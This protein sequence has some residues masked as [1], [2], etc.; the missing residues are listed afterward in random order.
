MTSGLPRWLNFIYRNGAPNAKYKNH[1]NRSR[2]AISIKKLNIIDQ[3]ALTNSL[4]SLIKI[5]EKSDHQGSTQKPAVSTEPHKPHTMAP[6]R[7]P[8]PGE[9]IK[10]YRPPGTRQPKQGFTQSP[11][12]LA[13]TTPAYPQQQYQQ[14]YQPGIWGHPAWSSSASHNSGW[15]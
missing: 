15:Q 9:Q 10:E 7:K 4:C 3:E 11:S 14:Q 13:T 6:L 5:L 12:P 2:F 8:K 1:H